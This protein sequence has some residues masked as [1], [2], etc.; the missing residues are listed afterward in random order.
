MSRRFPY[1]SPEEGKR[2]DIFGLEIRPKCLPNTEK[3]FRNVE[4]VL[5]HTLLAGG[6]YR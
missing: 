4:I 5:E 6:S 1:S 2:L 3:A